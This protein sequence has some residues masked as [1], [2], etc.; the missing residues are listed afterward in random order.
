MKKTNTKLVIL[1]ILLICSV[2]IFGQLSQDRIED[3]ARIKVERF[4]NIL[5]LTPTQSIQL[6]KETIK[7]M[8]AHSSVA[9]SKNI[10]EE[11]GKNLDRHYASLTSFKPQQLATLKLMD[12]LDRQSR[13][14]AF[15]DLM[16]IYGQSS[17]FAIAVATYN[18]NI[19]MPIL[20]SYRKDLDRYISPADRAVIT[21]LRSKMIAKYNFIHSIREYNASPKTEAIVA[22]I[23][24]EILIEIQ[25]SAL[26]ALLQK[27][28][29]QIIEIR[30]KLNK[31][32]KQIN[33]DIQLIYEENMLDNHRSQLEAEEEFFNMLGI[34]KLLKDSFLFLLDGDSRAASFKIN[35]LYLMANGLAVSDQF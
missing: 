30:V 16:T 29:E 18:W 21:E 8:V 27:Y 9:N 32:E 12:S 34:S 23:Q 20:V 35:T 15:K 1:L 28:D 22:T 25:E 19:V 10:S 13:R 14:E 17:E 6:K 2:D 11:I 3:I 33:R 5:D 24:D 31:H 26:P 4:Q 7:M